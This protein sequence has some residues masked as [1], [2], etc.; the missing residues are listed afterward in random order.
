MSGPV[1]SVDGLAHR[2]GS[3]TVLDGV[4]FDVGAGE[5]VAVVGP[6]GAGKTTLFRGIT[7]LVRPLAGEVSVAGRRLSSLNGSDLRAAR[8]EVAL[9]FQQF[10]LVRRLSALDNVIAGHLAD[11]PT[12]RVLLRRPGRT[13][14]AHARD[15]LTEV[16]LA[17]FAGVRAD[18]LSGGQQ[19]RVAIARALAQRSRIILADEPVSN[20]D[21]ASAA[22]VLRALR[23][24]ARDD[25]IAVVCNLHQVELLDGFADRVIGLRA[26]RIVTDVPAAEF[27][28]HHR[29][30][31]YAT[32]PTAN[33]NG[34]APS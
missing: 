34:K 18:R 19:Q 4:S 29:D 2:Y 10:N 17:E 16:G 9:I 7:R 26:G 13:V 6:S 24:V 11:L 33:P 5:V 31:V 23:T 8:R 3:R 27:G 28:A 14:R 12:W 25:G 21:P 30:A 20:L 32:T 15:C 22:G 1:L